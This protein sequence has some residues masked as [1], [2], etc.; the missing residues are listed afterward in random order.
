MDEVEEEERVCLQQ[1][2]VY[3]LFFIVL[4]SCSLEIVLSLEDQR[5]VRALRN[6]DR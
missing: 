6:H 2:F 3:V 5:L 1:S 4:V